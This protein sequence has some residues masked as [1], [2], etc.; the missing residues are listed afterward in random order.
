MALHMLH[1]RSTV[2]LIEKCGEKLLPE[3]WS[4]QGVWEGISHTVDAR[5]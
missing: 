5:I 2:L 3:R 4:Q 1:A